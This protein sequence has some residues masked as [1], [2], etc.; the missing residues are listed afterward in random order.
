[1]LGLNFIHISKRAGW[2]HWEFRAATTYVSIVHRITSRLFYFIPT[3]SYSVYVDNRPSHLK[4]RTILLSYEY[5]LRQ[6]V[7]SIILYKMKLLLHSQTEQV[8]PLK[9][10]NVLVI[11]SH[12]FIRCNYLSMLELKSIYVN[13]RSTRNKF[14]TTKINFKLRYAID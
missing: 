12:T 3:V 7:T 10:E 5:Y 2:N 1:M 13:K 14:S 4:E 11:S 9:F 6:V 8:A